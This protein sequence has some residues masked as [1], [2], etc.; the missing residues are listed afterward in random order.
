MLQ[1]PC[2]YC[3]QNVGH[4]LNEQSH[5]SENQK[6]TLLKYFLGGEKTGIKKAPEQVVDLTV[7]LLSKGFGKFGLKTCVL[8]I[9]VRINKME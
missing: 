4:F 9:S 5:Y 3:Q 7:T 2:N 6:E 8:K 1:V